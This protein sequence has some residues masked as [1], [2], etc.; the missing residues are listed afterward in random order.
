MNFRG[1][2]GEILKMWEKNCARNCAFDDK[3]KS[4]RSILARVTREFNGNC[5]TLYEFSNFFFFQ[6]PCIKGFKKCIT[7]YYVTRKTDFNANKIRAQL[8][9]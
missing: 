2:T 1:I 4:C 7:N 5:Y 8:E 3:K 9:N 6:Y